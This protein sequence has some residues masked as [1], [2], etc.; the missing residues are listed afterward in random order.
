MVNANKVRSQARKSAAQVRELKALALY[1]QGIRFT[2]I[3]QQLELHPDSVM[4][5]VK[6]GLKRFAAESQSDVEE[7][8]ARY[9]HGLNDLLRAWWPL[10]VGEFVDTD[11]G[12]PNPPDFRA[13]TLA[14]QLLEKIA[15]VSAKGLVEDKPGNS[16]TVN[17]QMNT[18]VDT[19]RQQILDQLA[20]VAAKTQVVEGELA[21]ANANLRQ[22]TGAD[23]PNDTP[24]PPDTLEET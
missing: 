23:N 18:Q 5:I 10:A 20:R 9:L 1:A 17:V 14:L 8:R 19:A 13:A 21:G 4:P 15:M 7:A 3:A 11:T 6:R 24:A 16:V 12:L 2:E 22:L